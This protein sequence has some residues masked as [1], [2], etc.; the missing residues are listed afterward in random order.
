[1]NRWIVLCVVLVALPAQ[2]QD[3]A[4]AHGKGAVASLGAAPSTSRWDRT[5]FPA[6]PEAPPGVTD[7]RFGEFF[8]PIGDRGLVLSGKLKRLDGKRV[9]ILGYMVD[10]D[11]APPGTFLFAPFPQTLHEHEYGLADDLPPAVLF[12]TAPDRGDRQVPYTPGLLLLTGTLDV[13]NR[14]EPDGRVSLVRL[15]LDPPP[16][17]G[18]SPTQFKPGKEN[19]HVE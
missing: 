13:G 7:L 5:A 18:T 10:R 4:Y 19:D 9:R 16:G 17:E 1:M 2:A 3:H 12:V 14:E 8:G 15:V 11:L 6:V